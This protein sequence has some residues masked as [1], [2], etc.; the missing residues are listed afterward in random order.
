VAPPSSL[1]MSISMTSLL[2]RLTVDDEGQDLVEYVLLT[3]VVGLAI[4]VAINLLD[5]VMRITYVSWDGSMQ[6]IWEPQDP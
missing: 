5:D 4:I 1:S 3:A 2:F 6:A